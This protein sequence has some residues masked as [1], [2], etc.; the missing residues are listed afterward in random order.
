VTT[1]EVWV[2][3]EE[4]PADTI[5]RRIKANDAEHVREIVESM[6]PCMRVIAAIQEEETTP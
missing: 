1:F 3:P 5:L 4:H 6:S 2:A